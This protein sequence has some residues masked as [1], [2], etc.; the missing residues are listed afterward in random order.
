[1]LSWETITDANGS[2]KKII[3]AGTMEK[4]ISLLANPKLP[5]NNYSRERYQLLIIIIR[6]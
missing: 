2:A 1:M 5:G 4:L 3:T 6:F